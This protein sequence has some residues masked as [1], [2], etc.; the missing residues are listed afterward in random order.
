MKSGLAVTRVEEEGIAYYDV[1]EP[2]SGNTFRFYEHEYLLAQQLEP[3]RSLSEIS[4]W[5]RRELG[6]ESRP[7]R[8]SRRKAPRA[9]QRARPPS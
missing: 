2:E 3:G 6:V 4:G 9:R 7:R 8:C 1:L 5:V